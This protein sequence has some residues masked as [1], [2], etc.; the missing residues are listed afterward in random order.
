MPLL[1]D[2]DVIIDYLCGRAEAVTYIESLTE[3]L[4]ISTITIAELYS[5]AREGD[6]RAALQTSCPH[7]KRS[8]FRP[9]L[10]LDADCFDAT[11]TKAQSRFS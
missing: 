3:P 5:G 6:E 8:M 10:P 11:G 9:Q 2:T 7:L 1:L 4:L